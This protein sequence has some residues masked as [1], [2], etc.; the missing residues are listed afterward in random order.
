MHRAR[1]LDD[2]STAVVVG[3]TQRAWLGSA[4]SER[5][6]PGLAQDTIIELSASRDITMSALSTEGRGSRALDAVS[7]NRAY[8]A[9][10]LTGSTLGVSKGSC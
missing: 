1:V 2:T 3:V 9:I 8:S 10:I 7:P 6:R 5:V 4:N